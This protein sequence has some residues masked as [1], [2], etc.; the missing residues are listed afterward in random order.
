MREI[1]GAPPK[2]TDAQ[3]EAVR[4][5]VVGKDPRQHGMDFGLWT[6]KYI[7]Q[8]IRENVSIEIGLTAIGHATPSPW[9]RAC[10]TAQTCLSA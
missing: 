9:N 3:W 10:Q 7:Q 6:R 5:M 1:P 4:K 2:M 8:L